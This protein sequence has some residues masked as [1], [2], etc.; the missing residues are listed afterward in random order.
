MGSTLHTDWN[1]LLPLLSDEIIQD[2][3]SLREFID[4]F[5]NFPDDIPLKSIRPAMSTVIYKT[6]CQNWTPDKF[7]RGIPGI[8]SCERVHH[9]INSQKNTLIAVTARKVPIDWADIKEIFNWDWELFI[10]FWDQEQK[11]LF[12]HG[13][14]NN[15]DYRNLAKAVAGEDVELIS[16]QAVFRCFS[17]VNRMRLQNV[18]L[19][20]RLGRLVRYTG[21]MGSDVEAGLTE[22]QKQNTSKSVLFGTGYENG[23]KVTVGASRK[24]RIWSFAT[25]NIQVL[26]RWCSAVGKKVLDE[27]IDLDEVL[28]GTLESEIIAK[29][30]NR[31]PVGVDWPEDI[32]KESETAYSFILDDDT[33]W[34]LLH[35]D[36]S[37]KEPTEDGEIKLAISSGTANVEITLALF[38]EE[39]VKDFRFIVAGQRKVQVKYRSHIIPLEDFFDRF[40][41]VVWFV[42]GSSLEGNKLTSLKK[43]YPPYDRQKIQAWDW[44]GVDLTKESQ[45]VTKEE[46]SIQYRAIEIIKSGDYQIIFDDD[47]T[48]EAADIV[49]IRVGEEADSRRAIDI[50]FYHCKFSK[51][52]PG[53]RIKDLYEVCGQA[54][55]SIHWMESHDKQV[56]LFTHLLRR[57]PKRRQGQ[58]AS[59]FERGDS[60]ELIKIREMSRVCPIRL[61]IFIIQPGLSKANA[62]VDQ[63]ELLSVTE[64]HLMETYNL[65]FVVI[66]SM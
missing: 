62:T 39:G 7:R 29:R 1:F 63:L 51:A 40:S 27:S 54:Q 23:R 50:E 17:G 64:N 48:G 2:Q 58:T 14:G 6:K 9:D 41:P 34:Q 53:E 60:N 59:R 18:G 26:T 49:A 55:K 8:A 11:L 3:V 20:E 37:L 52:K 33:E 45:G 30:P 38:E 42:D 66:A 61:K 13:S 22:A 16:E 32:Y 21:R 28:K 56:E 46:D 24:G 31:M 57:E 12:I 43:K 35:T 10:L 44:T 25:T 5:A 15:G 4:G 65:P 47:D 36:I 19:T